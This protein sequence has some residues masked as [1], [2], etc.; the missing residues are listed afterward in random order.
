MHPKYSICMTS[1][2][3]GETI[4]ASFDSLL[5]Q[6]DESFELIVVDG[7]SDDARQ[8]AFLSS[9]SDR[10]R[11]L[12]SPIRTEVLFMGRISRG[13]ARQ[14][15]FE[16]SRGDYILSSI[17]TDDTFRPVLKD[18]LLQYHA[19]FEGKIVSFGGLTVLPRM[20]VKELGGWPDLQWNE[21]GYLYA[22][23]LGKGLYV[24]DFSNPFWQER[25]VHEQRQNRFWSKY[26]WSR[27]K[28]RI[29][30]N[31]LT[32]VRRSNSRHKTS[33]YMI[34]T[35]AYVGALFKPRYERIGTEEYI[36]L[37]GGVVL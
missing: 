19:H 5:P 30:V 37:L 29:G 8:R 9:L 26:Y 13:K 28:W 12:G 17:D 16:H 10:T 14:I 4:E 2:N 27:D 34:C 6:L 1:R 31:P 3:D 35:L 24:A 23:A 22:K 7:G 11:R 33:Y 15:A 20:L 18:M 21:D 32:L 36:K 25:G